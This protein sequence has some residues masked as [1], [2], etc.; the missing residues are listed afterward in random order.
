[1][2]GHEMKKGIRDGGTAQDGRRS[3][4]LKTTQPTKA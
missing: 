4:T 1:M 2:T 3:L